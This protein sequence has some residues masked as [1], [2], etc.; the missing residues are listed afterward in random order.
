M[1]L[2]LPGLPPRRVI[3]NLGTSSILAFSLRRA[4]QGTLRNL[5]NPLDSLRMRTYRPA[6]L[7]AGRFRPRAFRL[8]FFLVTSSASAA[9]AFRT[10][11]TLLLLPESLRLRLL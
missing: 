3:A 10:W 6:P 2:G 4:D 1:P 5:S 11:F 7:R 8:R 9:D